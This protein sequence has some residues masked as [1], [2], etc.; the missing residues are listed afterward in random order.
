[1]DH[2]LPM[3]DPEISGLAQKQT[4]DFLADYVQP[5]LAKYGAELGAE[6]PVN[7]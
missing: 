7:V 2:I 5:V 3:V 6:A 4:E 1:M